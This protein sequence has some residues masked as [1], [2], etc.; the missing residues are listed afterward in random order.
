MPLKVYKRGEI[1]HYRGKVA[2]RKLRGTTGTANREIAE[3]IAN[4]IEA[5]E[6][7]RDLHGP[8]AVLRFSDA[9]AAYLK[10]GK[11]S[12][13]I[14]ALLD[15]WKETLIKDITAG[16]I[17]QAAIDLYP[18]AGPATRNRHVIVPTVAIINHCAELEQCP[19]IRVKRFKVESR[20]KEPVTWEW[21]CEFRKHAPQSMGVLA[22]FMFLTGARISE[23]LAVRWPD[24]D[25]KKRTV[26]IKQTKV[27][28][29]RRAHLPPE[30]VVALANQDR[31]KPPFVYETRGAVLTTWLRTCERAGL[32]RR[33]LHAC[34]H[35]F[36]TAML[37]AGYD[38]VTVAKRG[39][40]KTPRHVFETYGHA[41][42]DITITDRLTD[43]TGTQEETQIQETPVKS[44]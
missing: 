30:L 9:A 2:G 13:F 43:T 37:H 38:A 25:F 31:N 28:A 16:A 14:A 39:G 8:E 18:N 41:V 17:R 1:Y 11:P 22:M 40:W 36:A 24:I 20:E 7:K 19:P 29:E 34:R 10:A 44:A 12:R 32:P 42:E 26:L 6:W 35:G 15:H 3:Q 21:I 4:R 27:G 23:A 5:R 33:N